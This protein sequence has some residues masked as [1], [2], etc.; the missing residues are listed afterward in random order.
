MI[1]GHLMMPLKT[2]SIILRLIIIKFI[3]QT[4]SFNWGP[5]KLYWFSAVYYRVSLGVHQTIAMCWILFICKGQT[6][7]GPP[8]RTSG[9]MKLRNYPKSKDLSL[10]L[11]Y[12]NRYFY[13]F[14]AWKN[15]YG[16]QLFKLFKNFSFILK[17]STAIL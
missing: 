3:L 1:P 17:F 5:L 15:N 10:E 6:S 7:Q 13:S 12:R 2:L 4:G 14:K 8:K 16:M 9:D 11:P